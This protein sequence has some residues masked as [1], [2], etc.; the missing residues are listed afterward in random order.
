MREYNIYDIAQKANVS[1]A[2]VSR[3]I[4][5]S[6]RV[7]PETR[8][9]ILSVIENTGYMKRTERHCVFHNSIA[10]LCSGN[11]SI[12]SAANI[13]KLNYNISKAGYKTLLSSA[14]GD[15]IEKKRAITLLNKSNIDGIIIDA[16]DFFNYSDEENEELIK[17]IKKPAM[18]ING[19]FFGE[20]T[21]CVVN[22]LEKAASEISY[23][24]IKSDKKNIMFIFDKMTYG[25][26][27]ILKGIHSTFSLYNYD[28]DPDFSKMCKNISQTE[29]AISTLIDKSKLPD[30]IITSN[31]ILA[32]GAM[33]I[34]AKYG[35]HI[36]DDIQILSFGNSK[37]CEIMTP[38]ISSFDM[39]NEDVCKTAVAGLI[40][41]INKN[42]FPS[43]VTI[44]PE[45]IKRESTNF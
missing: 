19:S 36:P 43:K 1:I 7:K 34:I 32:G 27:A 37:I 24:M 10:V 13:E 35:C 8:E 44:L 22:D 5:N 2:T 23:S 45:L 29:K 3:V 17:V 33:K 14:D 30:L 42:E 40:N 4:N 9:K 31:D 28:I 15:I 12:N 38:C 11:V 18:I 20:T 26:K 16:N 41:I 21:G 39:K 25:V 6:G